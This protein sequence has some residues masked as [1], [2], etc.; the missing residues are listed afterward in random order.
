MEYGISQVEGFV[1]NKYPTGERGEEE[2]PRRRKRVEVNNKIR[3]DCYPPALH[4]PSTLHLQYVGNVLNICTEQTQYVVV[5]L[6]PA[7][8]IAAADGTS[9][10]VHLTEP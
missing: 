4:S 6:F 10:C 2:G 1:V 7:V 8:A 5:L 9:I 3:F